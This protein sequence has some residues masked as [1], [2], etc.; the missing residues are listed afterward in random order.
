MKTITLLICLVGLFLIGIF[1]LQKPTFAL[2]FKE[3]EII[4]NIY[5]LSC[6]VPNGAPPT[7]RCCQ[8][9]KVQIDLSTGQPTLDAISFPVRFA[10][11]TIGNTIIGG[12]VYRGDQF[13]RAIAGKQR[14]C[15]QG[16]PSTT[17]EADASCV[18]MPEGQT[19]LNSLEYLCNSL[20]AG[21]QV[22]CKKCVSG[23]NNLKR[24][25]VWTGAGCIYGDAASFIQNTLLGWGIGLAG[26][27]ALFSIIYAAFQMEISRGNPE[28]L[29][30]SQELLTSS[31]MGL[32][33]IIFS[34]FILRVIGVEILKIPGFGK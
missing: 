4:N 3:G 19:S 1:G 13:L 25:G 31:I 11:E 5:A 7:N 27:L 34:V 23:N 29:K 33:L 12:L 16:N 15:Y 17:N 24:G 14:V 8:P 32:L 26:T 9:T 21:E 2:G 18:C 30:K 10:V 22:D 6:G 20:S 28:R